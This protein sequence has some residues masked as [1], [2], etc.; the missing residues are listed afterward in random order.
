MEKIK[1]LLEQLG[2]S[3]ELA[4][5]I[6]GALEE[7]KND[8]R[9]ELEAEYRKRLAKAKKVCLEEVEAHKGDLSRKVQIY[10]ESKADQIDTQLA[11]QAVVKESAAEAKLQELASVLEGVQANGGGDNAELQ[12]AIKQVTELKESV[13][14]ASSN[15]KVLKE[16]A[17]RAQGIAETTLKR[18]KQLTEEISIKDKQ[19][20]EGLAAPKK[21]V[22]KASKK[23]IGEGRKKKATPVSSTELS[24]KQVANKRS[25]KEAKKPAPN[26]MTGFDP[27][28]IAAGM[29]E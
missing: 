14:K 13:K 8:I 18:N 27:N 5:S 2:A 20:A 3:K 23:T 19:I 9:E 11:Q 15:I 17:K 22:E 24:D 7:T 16:Q 29:D 25:L 26:I 28:T 6:I 4:D 1:A 10:L 12:T 21:K